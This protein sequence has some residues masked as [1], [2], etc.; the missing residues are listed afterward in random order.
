MV[1]YHY[2]VQCKKHCADL[3]TS[4]IH[5]SGIYRISPQ[6]SIWFP[7][8]CDME[9]DGGGWTIVQRR[10]NG[11][12]SFERKWA[13]YKE[14]DSGFILYNKSQLI[15]YCIVVTLYS[16]QFFLMT[17]RSIFALKSY[18]NADYI[19]NIVSV[20]ISDISDIF[21]IVNCQLRLLIH[22]IRRHPI[23][24]GIT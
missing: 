2:L 20:E 21:L 10:M 23:L 7:V 5:E 13:A 9:T 12:D 22:W 1:N 16:N 15:N 11:S 24:L 14:G 18:F 3:Y 17:F 8:W 19:S 6:P 4:G